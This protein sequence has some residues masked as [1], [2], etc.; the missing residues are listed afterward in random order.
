MS[1]SS[2]L[3]AYF[4]EIQVATQQSHVSDKLFTI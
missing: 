1:S 2:T 4:S 3:K